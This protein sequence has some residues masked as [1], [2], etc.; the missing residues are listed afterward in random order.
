[1][2]KKNLH[3]NFARSLARSNDHRAFIISQY[4]L[5]SLIFFVLLFCFLFFSLSNS[6]QS[7]DLCQP[8]LLSGHFVCCCVQSAYD[9]LA[10]A[11]FAAAKHGQC[12]NTVIVSHCIHITSASSLTIV[13][14]GRL[15][16]CSLPQL[17]PHLN[18]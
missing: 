4:L 3:Q 1:M 12:V 17:T 10:F 7:H 15:R 5:L 14:V 11:L 18:I 8:F 6:V 13:I 16:I 9:H 2:R